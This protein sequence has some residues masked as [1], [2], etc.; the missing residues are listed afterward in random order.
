MNERLAVL[1]CGELAGYLTTT[2]G[3]LFSYT[4]DYLRTGEVA[5]SAQL[6]MKPG[7][8]PAEKVAAYLAGL[9]PENPA[10]RTEWARRLGVSPDDDAE[11]LA[12]MGWDCPGA[13][14]FCRESQLTELQGRAGEYSSV[15]E[16]QIA[17]RIRALDGINAS[18]SLPS[19][20]WSLGGQQ[21]KF[22]LAL[23]N[24]QWHS[25]EGS[26]AT[27]HIL[28]P[29][30]RHLHHQALIEH[31]TMTAARLAGVVVAESAFARFEEQWAIVVT[32]FDRTINAEQV[33]RLHQEDFAQA[34]GRMPDRKYESRG[35]PG[36][37]EMARV[38]DRE[39]TD[40]L[41]DRLAL[42]DF[43]II[44]LVAG[45]PD[46]HAKN[47]SLLRAPRSTV[48]APLYDLATGLA[49]E[50]SQ[51]DRS[52]AVSI[53]GERLASRIRAK[54]WAKMAH[55][56]NLDT[57]LV[58]RRVYNLAASFPDLFEAALNKL[59]ADTPGIDQV[60]TRTMPH[61]TQHTQRIIA[62]L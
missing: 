46:G 19:E 57:D 31:A 59:P 15:T 34:C 33:V 42:A 45:A 39:S 38:V 4:S 17:A 27:T 40:R 32:R 55:T 36:L 12:S 26:A 49:Y 43:A 51:V 47:I 25:A 16:A 35:G 52:V 9:L 3:P 48:I 20:H 50:A 24:G 60:L 1:L 11:I 41:G 21:E 7:P 28:K 53:G 5:L 10:T 6:P 14:Q 54:Q 44:N 58:L 29:G 18:W 56:L 22:A 61:L 23:L 37:R 2:D 13:V 8:H 30:I 62:Q